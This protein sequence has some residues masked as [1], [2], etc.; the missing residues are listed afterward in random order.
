[1]AVAVCLLVVLSPLSARGSV[2][3]RS[4]YKPPF[5]GT[6][7]VTGYANSAIACASAKTGT[8]KWSAGAGIIR[9][10]M[11]DSAR[12]CN[13]IYGGG[14]ASSSVTID[15]EIP[16]KVA[17]SGNHTVASNWALDLGTIN[18]LT[19]SGCP[20]KKVIYYPPK[21]SYSNGGCFDSTYIEMFIGT[22]LFDA[23]NSS[24]QNYNF[25]YADV[26]NFSN[27]QNYTYCG[28]YN[29]RTCLNQTYAT[30]NAADYGSNDPGMS[31][32]TW[33]GLTRFTLWSNATNMTA[34]D[35]F[36]MV[37]Q[38][39]FWSTVSVDMF[40]L[41]TPWL[42]AATTQINLATLGTGLRL[43]SIRIA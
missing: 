4:V 37:I 25:S 26:Y 5:S 41:K 18:A 13:G 9:D 8:G 35:K 29:V 1:M 14:S 36:E 21:N 43:N 27:W 7:N 22:A 17:L 12:A 10:R 3:A 15:V 40:D 33:N 6:Q 11:Y 16:F 20:A 34:G 19:S 38:L 39:H 31:S 23:V 30:F 2:P 42:A 32:F 24:W 28:N